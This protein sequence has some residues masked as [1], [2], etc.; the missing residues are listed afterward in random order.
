MLLPMRTL[1]PWG[2]Q[3]TSHRAWVLPVFLSACM[4]T[5]AKVDISM[6]PDGRVLPLSEEAPTQW[7]AVAR[8]AIEERHQI[9]EGSIE[10]LSQA[11]AQLLSTGDVLWRFKFL[12]RVNASVYRVFLDK[13]GREV[14]GESL[15]AAENEHRRALWGPFSE[16]CF[17]QIQKMQSDQVMEFI[18]W[19]LVSVPTPDFR[20]FSNPYRAKLEFIDFARNDMLATMREAFSRREIHPLPGTYAVSVALDRLEVEQ[21]ARFP[22]IEVIEMGEKAGCFLRLLFR[23]YELTPSIKVRRAV[24]PRTA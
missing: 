18:V 1:R 15:M 10:F 20:E 14:D 19:P 2:A 16:N 7:I 8:K 24:S 11:Q 5:E 17:E 22:I 13:L 6:A 3:M 4:P 9:S 21:L 23:R 12:D